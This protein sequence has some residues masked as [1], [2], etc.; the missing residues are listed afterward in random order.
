MVTNRVKV[1][2]S[3][4]TLPEMCNAEPYFW[5]AVQS[6][7]DLGWRGVLF[8]SFP[9]ITLRGHWSGIS[10]GWPIGAMYSGIWTAIKEDPE[11][12]TNQ[13]EGWSH[14]QKT[15]SPCR[16]F[17]TAVLPSPFCHSVSWTWPFLPKLIN[18]KTDLRLI[19][20]ASQLITSDSESENPFVVVHDFNQSI[21]NKGFVIYIC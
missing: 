1:K 15:Q 8:Y 10:V 9:M 20:I 2:W 6:N 16:R 17:A 7:A 14:S 12:V 13:I 11:K 3:F 5:L 18:S 19:I 21:M 4:C